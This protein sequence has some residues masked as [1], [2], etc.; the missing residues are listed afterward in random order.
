MELSAV[1][2]SQIRGECDIPMTQTSKYNPLIQ[3]DQI[4]I[5]EKF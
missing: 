2:L 4:A 1:S 3:R 5:I